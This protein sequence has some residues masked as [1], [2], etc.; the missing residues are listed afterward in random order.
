VIYQEVWIEQNGICK[1]FRE[2]AELTKKTSIVIY[3][4]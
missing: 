3:T 1:N 2:G 4:L